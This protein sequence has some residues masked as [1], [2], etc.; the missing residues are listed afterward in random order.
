MRVVSTAW[1]GAMCAAVL[2]SGPA[3]ADDAGARRQQYHLQAS[4]DV[5]QHQV[6]GRGRIHFV[7][8]S[9]LPLDALYFHLYPNAFEHPRTVF[10][11]EGGGS[12]RGRALVHPGWLGVTS[13][14]TAQGADLLLHAN[15]EL[16]PDDHT[17][18]HVAL[19]E[20]LAP[21][22]ALDL[23][24]EFVTQL[25][26]IVA[27]AG[28]TG[29]FHL[30]GQWYPKL[31]RL[32]ESGEWKSFPYHGLGE[33]YADFADYT[34]EL[35]VPAEY[36]I[37]SGGELVSSRREQGFRIETY[38]AERVHDVAAA[39]YPHFE[40]WSGKADRGRGRG[41][42]RG[43]SSSSAVHVDDHVHVHELAHPIQIDLYAPRGYGAAARRQLALIEAGLR[44]FSEAYGTYPYRRLTVVLPPRTAAAAAGME[45]P[46]L[47]AS[48]GSWLALPP[49]WPD[50]S[51][52]VVA[53]HELAHQWFSSLI[54]SDEVSHPMLDEGLAEWTSL[55]FLRAHY[56][57]LPELLDPF[58]LLRATFA[59]RGHPVPSSLLPAYRYKDDE[60]A[61]AVYL[62][63]A[64]VLDDIQRK[65][66]RPQLMQALGG[67]ARAQRFRHP[68]PSDLFAAFDAAFGAGFA[69]RELRPALTGERD[70]APSGSVEPRVES[71]LADVLATLQLL[72]GALGP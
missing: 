7:N 62:R 3:R 9:A 26:E 50:P 5:E 53:A 27:R 39:V 70:R 64:V 16:L 12:I 30:L 44:W 46:T 45:Y 34:L 72:L 29:S 15:S 19:P 63:P 35:R 60:L 20:P 66:G 68:D 38:R 2:S 59:F 43:R 1:L 56:R 49:S 28:Y 6:T 24:V 65:Y 18:L 55:D 14:R 21:G 25:P 13:L 22:A 8:H 4:L 32:E 41:R 54:A 33:F 47:F 67:Y 23:E 40:H 42:G 57:G 11:R 58:A 52:D 36:A 17:Q 51:H 48:G 69:E 31:A 61:R 37:A 71:L 10:M